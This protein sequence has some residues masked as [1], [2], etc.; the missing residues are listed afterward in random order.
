[1]LLLPGAVVVPVDRVGPRLSH[2]VVFQ[3]FE[4]CCQLLQADLVHCLQIFHLGLVLRALLFKPGRVIGFQVL[5]DSI[6]SGVWTGK[7][8]IRSPGQLSGSIGLP[9][10]RSMIRA[11]PIA[12]PSW[13][14][15]AGVLGGWVCLVGG[16]VVGPGSGAGWLAGG[17][18]VFGGYAGFGFG[19]VGRGGAGFG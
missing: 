3:L 17:E 13:R 4:A 2:A 14:L 7:A 9:R 19:G 16:L 5:Q 11:F 15:F 6:G 10:L 12:S 18:L 8:V 1:M